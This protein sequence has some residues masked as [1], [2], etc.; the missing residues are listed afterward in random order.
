MHAKTRLF[1]LS[2]FL[3]P[4]ILKKFPSINVLGRKKPPTYPK[5]NYILKIVN[6]F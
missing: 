3:S 2:G 1:G 6:T 5:I 4:T